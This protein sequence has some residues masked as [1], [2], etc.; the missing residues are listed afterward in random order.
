MNAG[1]MNVGQMNGGTHGRRGPPARW[2]TRTPR[3]L[4]STTRSRS[5]HHPSLPGSG[6][7]AVSE[8]TD[9]EPAVPRAARSDLVLTMMPG[10]DGIETLRACGRCPAS[11]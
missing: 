5:D 11:T 1:Q 9:G 10:I 4:S 7:L 6:W 8:A 3:V 2:R